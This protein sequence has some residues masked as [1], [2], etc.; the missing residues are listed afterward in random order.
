MKLKYQYCPR[1]SD[2]VCAVR[3]CAELPLDVEGEERSSSLRRRCAASCARVTALTLLNTA[4]VA[5]CDL[6]G[7][8]SSAD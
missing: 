4:V 3:V 5:E 7:I 8:Y 6:N 2:A 1:I